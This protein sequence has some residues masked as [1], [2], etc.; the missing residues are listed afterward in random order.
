MKEVND[1]RFKN[2]EKIIKET[3]NFTRAILGTVITAIIL[4]IIFHHYGFI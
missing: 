2:L 1:E 3:R 4:P